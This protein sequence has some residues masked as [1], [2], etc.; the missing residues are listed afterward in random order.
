MDEIVLFLKRTFIEE[1]G[2]DGGK[3]MSIFKADSTFMTTFMTQGT[4][5]IRDNLITFWN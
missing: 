3:Q 5:K 1:T 4:K 2:P